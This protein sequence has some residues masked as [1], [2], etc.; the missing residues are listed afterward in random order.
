[1]K[2]AKLINGEFFIQS[3]YEMY[4][5]VS[6]PRDGV[7]DAFLEENNL[8]KVIEFLPHDE[9]TQKYHL[10]LT[11]VVEGNT[12]YTVAITP[13][14]DEEIREYKL[15]KIRE[16]RNQLLN[17]SDIEVT[18]DKWENYSQEIK[19]AWKTYRQ[20]LRDLPQTI[21]DLDNINWPVKPGTNN[22]ETIQNLTNI[23]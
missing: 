12:V 10:L 18:I 15:K 17:I 13:K 4:S 19:D 20:N 14:T 7:P 3:I 9:A 23:N 5:N 2:V 6:F 16:S 11:P 8:Y 21:Q 1:M 22:N